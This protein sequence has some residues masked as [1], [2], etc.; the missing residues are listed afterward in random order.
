MPVDPTPRHATLTIE[1]AAPTKRF[2]GV[3][4]VFADGQ[5]WVVDYRPRALWRGFADREV[6]VTG[7]CYEPSGEAMM[8]PHFEIDHLRFASAPSKA[9]PY[10]EVGPEQ[11][12]DGELAEFAWPANTKLAGTRSQRLRVGPDKE[13]EL[14]NEIERPLGPIKVNAR[15]VTRSPAY[16]ASTSLDLL[17]ILEAHDPRWEPEPASRPRYHACP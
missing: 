6:I 15:A 14:A 11:V 1:A 7:R 10:I 2:Q 16:T 13:Y 5:R 8:A 9:S 4:L 3:W 12:L 17:W